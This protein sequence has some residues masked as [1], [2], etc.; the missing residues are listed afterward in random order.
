[1]QNNNV[2]F[3]PNPNGQGFAFGT[4]CVFIDNWV[5]CWQGRRPLLDIGCGNDCNSRIALGAGAEVV[6]TEIDEGRL[7]SLQNDPEWGGRYGNRLSL[8]HALLPD[9][10]PFDD[11]SFDGILCAEV[12]HF[13]RYPDVIAAAWELHRLLAPGGLLALTCISSQL[14][15]L[16]NTELAQRVERQRQRNPER[17]SGY[18]DYVQLLQEAMARRL[19]E[20]EVKQMIE[21]HIQKIPGRCFHFFIAEQ[22]GAVIQRMGFE[23]LVCECGPAPHY[24]LI[25]HGPKDQVRILARK[26]TGL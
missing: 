12:F 19:G 16:R 21:G 11:N 1:M 17:L 6:A 14:H 13:L 22:L 3:E 23:L 24:P 2:M 15:I 25:E 5:S 26:R 18:M 10:M 8:V 9:A 4:P 20:P 7:A